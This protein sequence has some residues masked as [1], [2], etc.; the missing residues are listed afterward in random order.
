MQTKRPQSQSLKSKL[1]NVG[2]TIFTTMSAMAAEYDAI[3][4]SQGF[5]SFDCPEYLAHQAQAHIVEGKNQYAPMTGVPALN[6]QI[7][8]LVKRCYGRD[9]ALEEITVTSG[10]TEALFVAIQTVVNAGDE[11]IVFDPV[12]DSYEPGIELAGGKCVH[13]P[14]YAPDYQIDWQQVRQAITPKTKVI[15]LNSPHNPSGTVI[16]EQDI[17]ELTALVI[18]HDLYVISDEVYEH[19]VFDGG[20]HHSILRYD[21]LYQRTFVVSSFGKTFHITGWKIGYCVAPTQL[22]AEFRKIHQYVTF[23]TSTPMQWAIADMLAEQPKHVD[24]LRT[25]YQ[26]KRDFFANAMQGSRFTLLPCKGTYFQLMDYSQISDKDDMAFAEWMTKEK[27]I[28]TVPLSPFYGA[29]YHDKII[30]VCFAKDEAT[31]LKAAE[32]LREL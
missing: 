10:A 25:F 13:I 21:E 9:I 18:E 4:L 31:L 16:T 19:I 27:G 14:L 12:Y 28:A 1:P 3:N 23:S 2:T 15:M 11:V 5:P 26:Q 30:R 22:S 24:D 7:V 6:L 8:D 20:T 32:R 17:Q 29:D